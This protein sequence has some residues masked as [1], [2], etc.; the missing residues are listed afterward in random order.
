MKCSHVIR[1]ICS[2]D[3]GYSIDWLPHNQHL[4]LDSRTTVACAIGIEGVVGRTSVVIKSFKSELCLTI[5]LWVEVSA[6]EP[7]GCV[8]VDCAYEIPGAIHSKKAH[9]A[10]LCT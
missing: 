10:M 7:E 9:R 2:I 4:G 1:L 8:W 5:V 6:V 3:R